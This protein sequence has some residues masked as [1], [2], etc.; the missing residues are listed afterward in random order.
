MGFSILLRCC[1]PVNVA[2]LIQPAFLTAIRKMEEQ[3]ATN[4]LLPSI[5]QGVKD[6]YNGVVIRSSAEP[7]ERDAMERIL[8][9]DFPVQ[10]IVSSRTRMI[11]IQTTIYLTDSLTT[12]AKNKIRGVWFEVE[13][14]QAE[15]IPVLIKVKEI[16]LESSFTIKTIFYL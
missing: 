6:I 9:G 3:A 12:W 1:P 14:A 7:H 5:F 15:W 4:S 8:Q 13:S 11:L 16:H 2:S 10:R